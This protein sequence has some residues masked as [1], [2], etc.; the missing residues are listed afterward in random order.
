MI[1][2]I[3]DKTQFPKKKRGRSDPMRRLLEDHVSV[4]E[5]AETMELLSHVSATEDRANW[6]DKVEKFFKMEILGH[7]RY[8]EEVV[9]PSVLVS[10]PTDDVISLVLELQKEHGIIQ[11]EFVHFMDDFISNGVTDNR[12]RYRKARKKTHRCPC[13]F[14]MIC[15]MVASLVFWSISSARTQTVATRR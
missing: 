8:E 6:F 15:P 7:F 12:A 13:P 14:I 5:W 2:K 10:N 9:F 11:S 1:N 3:E 4:S